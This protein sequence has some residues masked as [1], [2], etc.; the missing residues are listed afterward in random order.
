MDKTLTDALALAE[1]YGLTDREVATAVEAATAAHRADLE[2][3]G[4]VTVTNPGVSGQHRMDP[5]AFEV[6]KQS[7]WQL[8]P[9]P[10]PEPEPVEDK[11]KPKPAKAASKKETS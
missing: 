2:R 6:L 1:H 9:E 7:G 3:P 11:P 4:L 8:V 10:E 5:E